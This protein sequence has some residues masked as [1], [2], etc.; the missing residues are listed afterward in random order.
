MLV[1]KGGQRGEQLEV[2]VF[3]YRVHPT[4]CSYLC[5]YLL[6]TIV[7]PSLFSLPLMDSGEHRQPTS[8]AFLLLPEASHSRG[9]LPAFCGLFDDFRMTVDNV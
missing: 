3:S 7:L 9:S 1:G 4:I 8:S 6:H 2:T 5:C